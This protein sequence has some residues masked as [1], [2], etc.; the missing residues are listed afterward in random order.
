MNSF[1]VESRWTIESIDRLRELANARVPAE[2]IS[3]A[4]HRPINEIIAKASELDL[5]LVSGR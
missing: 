3:Q 4:M 2:V 1:A 5:A